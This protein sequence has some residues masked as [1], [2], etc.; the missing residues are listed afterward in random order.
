MKRNGKGSDALLRSIALKLPEVDEKPHF[1]M[2]SF[3]VRGKIFATARV[4]EQ[5]AMLKLPIVLQEAMSVAHPGVIEAVPGYWGRN[6]A[7]FIATD[8]IGKRLLID[9]VGAAWAGVAPKSLGGGD[10]SDD[11]KRK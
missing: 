6:G 3:R 10:A 1:D 5:K 9:L 11:R 8:K 7:T 4:N 2:P